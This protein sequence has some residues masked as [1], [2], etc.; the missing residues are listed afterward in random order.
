MCV[1]HIYEKSN[2]E[3]IERSSI[4]ENNRNINVNNF[5][6]QN[7]IFDIIGV[8]DLN[9]QILL[10]EYYVKNKRYDDFKNCLHILISIL[11]VCYMIYNL[12]KLEPILL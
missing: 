11:S 5:A 12:M 8:T 2:Y 7:P 3:L 10:F 9:Y 6:E 1:R 4:T